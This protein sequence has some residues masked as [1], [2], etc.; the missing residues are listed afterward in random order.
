MFSGLVCA[1]VG[2]LLSAATY[3]MTPTGQS[4]V[5]LIALALGAA[6]FLQGAVLWRASNEPV[7]ARIERR[8]NER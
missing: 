8:P 1:L 6:R 2:L 5:A 4:S 3:A 7:P